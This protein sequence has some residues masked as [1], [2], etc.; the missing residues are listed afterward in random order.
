[1]ELEKITKLR[2]AEEKRRYDDACGVAHA[3]DLIG[4]RWAPLVLRELLFGPR[5]FSELKAD[6][7]GISANVLTQRLEG[8]EAAGVLRRT[9]LPPPASVQVYELTPWGYEAG[10]IFQAMGRWAVRSPAH[11]PS[12]PFSAVSL[13][14]SFRTMMD[15]S[16]TEGL[17]ARIGFRIGDD[18]FVLAIADG[19]VALGR[20]ETAGAAMGAFDF[21]VVAAA[22]AAGAGG[23]GAGIFEGAENE[24]EFFAFVLGQPILQVVVADEPTPL[25]VAVQLAASDF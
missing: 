12:K 16:R 6:L 9:R 10:P 14:L 18:R 3:L 17:D 19:T 21:G 4:E 13:L 2:Q 8:L 7:P 11:D 1:M 24:D 5:R 23:Y 25:V 22:G 20:A 15:L